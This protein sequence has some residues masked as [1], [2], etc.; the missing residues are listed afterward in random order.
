MIGVMREV[1]E[2]VDYSGVRLVKYV[3]GEART[4]MYLKISKGQRG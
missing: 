1:Q 2:K 3:P 4:V